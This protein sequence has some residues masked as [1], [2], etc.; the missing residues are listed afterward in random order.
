MEDDIV[1]VTNERKEVAEAISQLALA[2][3]GV[4]SVEWGAS[5]LEDIFMELIN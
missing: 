2:S 5:T 4:Y 3:V 1:F